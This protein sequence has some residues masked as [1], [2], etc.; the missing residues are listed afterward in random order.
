MLNYFFKGRHASNDFRNRI[1]A[2]ADQAR[3]VATDLTDDMGRLLG[4]NGI[5]HRLI[6]DQQLVRPD[7]A[8]IAR[9]I[10]LRTALGS[11]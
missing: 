2:H 7:T 8:A 10:A 3:G 5:L 11:G 1:L 6:Y 9:V 4:K